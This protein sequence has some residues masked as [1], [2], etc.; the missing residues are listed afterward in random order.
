M[1]ALR[2]LPV[3]QRAVVVLRCCEDLS[4]KEVAAWLGCRPGTVKSQLSKALAKLRA[5]PELAS[6]LLPTKGNTCG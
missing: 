5:D 4:E 2:A 6:A 1:A 3:R